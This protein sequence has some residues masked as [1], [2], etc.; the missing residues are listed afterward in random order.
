MNIAD[1]IINGNGISGVALAFFTVM[2]PLLITIVSGVF[3]LMS[4]Q[5]KANN[6][7]GKAADKADIAAANSSKAAANTQSIS[8]GFAD[9][10]DGKLD[11]IIYRQDTMEKAIQKHL[12]WHLD[13]Q[14]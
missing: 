14:A 6:A 12:E 13:S 2:I 1:Q 7:A 8:N 9:R 4:Q 3:A 11:R 10:V 5:R